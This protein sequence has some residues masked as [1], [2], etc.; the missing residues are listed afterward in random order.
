MKQLKMGIPKGSL[1]S[2]TIELFRKS[3]WRISVGSGSYFPNVD[4]EAGFFSNGNEFQR[5]NHSF[6]FM[7]PSDQCFYTYC[8]FSF[9]KSTGCMANAPH[10]SHTSSGR[11]ANVTLNLGGHKNIRGNGQVVAKCGR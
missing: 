10:H 7:I 11:G 2:A 3:G 6:F 4:D 1:E 8:F 9:D 5:R